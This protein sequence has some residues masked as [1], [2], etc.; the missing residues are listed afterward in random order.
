V[1]HHRL[2][3][4]SRPERRSLMLSSEGVS[5][6]TSPTFTMGPD[7]GA[8]LLGQALDSLVTWPPALQGQV[9]ASGGHHTSR[10]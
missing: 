9:T 8:D 10:A 3:T 2:R 7:E 6:K 4:N 5:L 1:F